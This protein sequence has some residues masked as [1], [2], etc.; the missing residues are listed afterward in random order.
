MHPKIL[1][2]IPISPCVKGYST[3]N[4][5]FVIDYCVCRVERRIE[6]AQSEGSEA[7]AETYRRYTEV[8]SKG[9]SSAYILTLFFR[10]GIVEENLRSF[11][12]FLLR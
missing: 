3:Y 5:I 12:L 9:S 6:K 8:S 1:F 10:N 11:Q 7:T 2:N 4:D